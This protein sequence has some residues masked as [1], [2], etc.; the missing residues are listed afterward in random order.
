MS[1]LLSVRNFSKSF[2]GRTVLRG[3]DLDVASGEVHALLGHNG[4]GKST[5]IKCLAG[6]HDPDP[7][8]ELAVKGQEVKLPLDPTA[9]R[10]LGLSFVHQQLGLARDMNVLENLQVG[11]FSCSPGW[12]IRWRD[13]ARQVRAALSRVGLEHVDPYRP[14]DELSEVEQAML[15][16][17]RALRDLDDAESGVLVLD[18]PTA[19]LPRDGVEHLFHAIE[20]VTA[21]GAGVLFVTHRLEEV[22]QIADRVTVLRDGGR[23]ATENADIGERKLVELIVGRPIEQLY[24]GHGVVRDDV[25]LSVDDLSGSGV[26]DFSVRVHR[27]EI[28]GVTGLVGMGHEAVP[29]L[30]FGADPAESGEVVVDGVT[31]DVQDLSPRSAIDLGLGLVPADR[32][33]NGG[34]ADATAKENTTLT[35]LTRYTGR[36]GWIDGRRERRAVVDLMR[37]VDVRPPEPDR[38][39]AEFSGGNQQKVVLAK[40]LATQPKALLL[41]EPTQGVDV[42]ARQGVFAQLRRYTDEGGAVL[43][44]STDEEELAHICDRVFVFRDGR[45]VAELHGDSLT[46]G[47]IVEQAFLSVRDVEQDAVPTTME[48]QP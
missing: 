39:F 7:G 23:V 19:Y 18:E 46:A 48:G 27:G 11:R 16:I 1:M 14:V 35:T 37:M 42:G 36:G 3:V 29:Y 15:A 22:Q 12:R 34:T 40:W 10:V 30:V 6:Y 43:L 33:V 21:E 2:Y 26:S 9:P 41:H 31:R 47:S 4:S 25:V 45:A 32:L 17:A 13:N 44:A 24:P 38:L 20:R 5:L 8:S 28:V